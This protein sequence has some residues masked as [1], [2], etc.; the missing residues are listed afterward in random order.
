MIRKFAASQVSIWA[1]IT[2]MIAAVTLASIY[3]IRQPDSS[4]KVVKA[5]GSIEEPTI[6]QK[7]GRVTPPGGPNPL[8]PR[9]VA[10]SAHQ[11]ITKPV[12][13]FGSVI[14][15]WRFAQ[16]ALRLG[17]NP[18]V[19][20]A[21]IGARECM[22]FRS[23]WAEFSH[24]SAGGSG[25]RI[26]GPL[27]PERQ[28]A[29]QGLQQRCNGFL[30]ASIEDSKALVNSLRARETE[31]GESFLGA[32]S[33]LLNKPS[34]T[35]KLQ[36]LLFSESPAAVEVGLA[37]LE[38]VWSLANAIGASDPSKGSFGLAALLAT[39]DVGKDCS[40]KGYASLLWCAQSGQC[41]M[42]LWSNWKDG[43]DEQK[44]T[45]VSALRLAIVTAIQ[46]KNLSS[47]GIHQNP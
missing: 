29:I 2:V 38:V 43:L 19:Y 22:G 25:S 36:R 17:E 4:P 26:P 11:P 7:R 47:I 34:D 16:D 9:S 27:T 3:F 20:E 14:D 21:F 6:V 46:T 45:E 15:I 24:F 8:A 30:S 23:M 12:D 39:C 28:L 33:K 42:P 44:I 1:A 35:A 13:S 40:V 5:V 18:L 32:E 10:I 37:S 41:S 31:F